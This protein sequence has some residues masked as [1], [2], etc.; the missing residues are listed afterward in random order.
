MNS[1]TSNSNMEN[2]NMS[3][4]NSESSN[5]VSSSYQFNLDY[6]THEQR[7]LYLKVSVALILVFVAA[8]GAIRL[9]TYANNA[10]AEGIMG[11]VVEARQ[12]LPKIVKEEKPLV[13]MFGS[14]MVG[15]GF[16]PRQFDREVRELGKDVKSFNFGF[17]GLN[18]YFQEILSRRIKEAFDAEGRKM[19]LVIIEFNPFQA[20]QTRWNGAKPIVDSFMTML[21]S[22]EELIEI[23]L[24]DPERGALLF[25]IKYIRNDVSAEMISSFFGRQM[26]SRN[27]AMRL[28]EPDE[29]RE[30]R[31]ELGRELNELFE[32]EYPDYVDTQWDYQWQGGGTIPEERSERTLQV[33]KEYYATF[34]HDTMKQNRR[35]SRNESSG[36]ES[37]NFE[38]LLVESFINLVENF[39]TISDSV[40]VVMMPRDHKW[41]KYTPEVQARLDAA[42]TQIEKETGLKI[43]NHQLLESITSEMYRDVTHLTKYEGEVIYTNHLVK[44]FADKL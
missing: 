32:K 10:S 42:V 2:T 29:L 19:K 1:S 5:E 4:K 12:A 14:S 38:P 25:N 16:S 21:A 11:R 20:S 39:K 37:L 40:E 41:I 7:V 43:H 24:D 18:P 3:V 36:I 17:G 27:R 15:A 28:E 23:A 33:F 35:M 13:M 6:S 31:R 8:M 34:Q 9:F 26:F 30:K 22:N 44:E